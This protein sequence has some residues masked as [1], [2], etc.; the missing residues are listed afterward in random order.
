MIIQLA[1]LPAT[2]KSTLGAALAERLPG[3]LLLDKDRVRAALYGDRHVEYRREQDDFCVDVLHQ[4]AARHLAQHTDAVVILDG[5]TCTRRYQIQ[6][7]ARLAARCRVPLRII[8]C[9]CPDRVAHQRLRADPGTHPATNRTVDLH[10]RL[11]TSAEAITLPTLRVDTDR[12]LALC[13]QA[14]L[15]HLAGGATQAGN[16]S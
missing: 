7:V 5:R 14:C 13:V 12:P 10:E 15:V 2:G 9:R 1:G 3:A 8:E 6:D 16:A 11:K 4:A